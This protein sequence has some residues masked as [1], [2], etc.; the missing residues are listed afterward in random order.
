LELIG[1]L[2]LLVCVRLINSSCFFVVNDK[3]EED[4]D[5]EDV[6]EQL[7]GNCNGSF[8]YGRYV[9]NR[10]VIDVEEFLS[11]GFVVDDVGC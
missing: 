8:S 5:D 9:L 7:D 2:R 1:R 4:E 3:D 11:S 6:A 10:F